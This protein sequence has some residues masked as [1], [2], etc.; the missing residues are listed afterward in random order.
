MWAGATVRARSVRAGRDGQRGSE[1]ARSVSVRAERDGQR[2]A[3]QRRGEA[4]SGAVQKR[5]R[6][7]AGGSG[8]ERQRGAQ[9]L[10]PTDAAAG[11]EPGEPEPRRGARCR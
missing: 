10:R 3:G 7:G 1:R 9:P 5:E 6:A 4:V 8:R 11:L 2:G